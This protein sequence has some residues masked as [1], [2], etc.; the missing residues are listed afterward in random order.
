MRPLLLKYPGSLLFMV[1][2]RGIMPNTNMALVSL[3]TSLKWQSSRWILP[4]TFNLAFDWWYCRNLFCEKTKQISQ[5]KARDRYASSSRLTILQLPLTIVLY[6]H[7]KSIARQPA[8]PVIDKLTLKLTSTIRE[9]VKISV[10]A[11]S[12]HSLAANISAESHCWQ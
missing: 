2:R 12:F 7:K 4:L 9:P 1:D 3:D 8:G 10:A 6:A 11:R 5:D